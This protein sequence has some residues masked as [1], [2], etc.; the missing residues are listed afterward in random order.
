V[1]ELAAVGRGAA[2]DSVDLQCGD[3][4]VDASELG[5]EPV[6]ERGA[7]S[8]SPARPRRGAFP[9]SRRPTKDIADRHSSRLVRP[10]LTFGTQRHQDVLDD[11]RLSRVRHHQVGNSSMT[12]GTPGSR[13]RASSASTPLCQVPNVNGAG[14]ST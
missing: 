1:G 12:T 5:G 2:D 6:V 13:P 8:S 10:G 3:R 11:R 7:T 4:V 9:L 14:A